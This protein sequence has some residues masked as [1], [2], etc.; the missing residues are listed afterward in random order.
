MYLCHA[1]SDWIT[2][3]EATCTEEGSREKVC[4][5]CGDTITETIPAIGHV[6]DEEY[7][8]DKEATC[9]EEGSK[10]IH[11]SVCDIIDESTVQVIDKKA[12]AYSDWS[13]TKE[14]TCT[15]EGEREKICSVCKEKMTEAIPATG[16]KWNSYY[17]IDET[18]TITSEGSMS[19]HCS[20]CDE[21]NPD[22]VQSIAK[23]TGSW[24][25]NSLGW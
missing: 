10:S 1:Y 22:S 20:V 24:K 17:T 21:I 2:T 15:E 5:D 16:H 12:H 6:W 7:T 13:V 14:A 4:A 9:A 19:I 23:L 3:K 18:P 25:K 8:V 11:C